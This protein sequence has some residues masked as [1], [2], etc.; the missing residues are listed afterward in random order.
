MPSL[1]TLEQKMEKIQNGSDKKNSERRFASR[2]NPFFYVC[3]S[4]CI[5]GHKSFSILLGTED[6]QKKRGKKDGTIV[7]QCISIG[8]NKHW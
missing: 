1:F 8:L 5:L 3:S 4:D 7:N 2:K 6:R